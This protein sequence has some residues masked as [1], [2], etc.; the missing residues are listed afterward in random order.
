[1]NK[2]SFSHHDIINLVHATT[3]ILQNAF[4]AGKAKRNRQ[5]DRGTDEQTMDKVIPVWHFAWLVPQ[6]AVSKSDTS[7][8][9]TRQHENKQDK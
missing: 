7:T 3:S 1:M 6:K 8:L 9:K 5:T 2:K 4:G